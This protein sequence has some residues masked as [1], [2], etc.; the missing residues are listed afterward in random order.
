ARIVIDTPRDAIGARAM[1]DRYLR[2]RRPDRIAGIAFTHGLTRMFGSDL[3]LLAW[4]RGAGL[5]LLD[6]LPF[7]KRA[8]TRAMLFG[9]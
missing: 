4:P 2:Q 6:A 3:P 1:T 9:F 8:F 5:A 7:T